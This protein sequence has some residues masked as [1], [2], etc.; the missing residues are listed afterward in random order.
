MTEPGPLT[1]Y[2]VAVTAQ[3]RGEE[4]AAML[5]RRGAEVVLAPTLRIV[6]LPSDRQ[7]RDTTAALLREPPDL[8]IVTTG[9]GFRGW[10]EAADGWGYGDR[11]RQIL[12]GGR[13]WARGP[14][15]VGAIRAAGLDEEWSAPSECGWEVTQRLGAESLEGRRIAVQLHGDPSDDYRAAIQAAG[16]VAVPVPVYRC[17]PAANQTAVRQLVDLVRSR[18]VDAITFTS[19]PAVGALL[20]AA[21]DLA[22]EVVGALGDADDAV[23]PVAVGPVTAAPLRRL[24]VAV[25]EPER[26][27]LGAMVRTVATALPERTRRLELANGRVLEI[28]G[29]LAIVDGE[30]RRLA[31]VPM[32]LL[33]ALAAANGRVLSRAQLQTRLPRGEADHAVDMAIKRLREGLGAPG[34]V[35][36]VIK[37]GYRLDLG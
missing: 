26:P 11:L 19:A 9:I 27:R 32:A 31:P 24:D 22:P 21:G 5:R 10:I 29:H 3:R 36:T 28:R 4:Q 8:T 33:S 13:L 34:C 20:R 12:A 14:K 15:A 18:R 7:L 35:A 30:V 37:R 1:G 6:P 2:T 23:L 17:V 16:A 25:V